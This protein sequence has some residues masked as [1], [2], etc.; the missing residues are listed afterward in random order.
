[1]VVRV[2]NRGQGEGS[3]RS[4]RG[5]V[6]EGRAFRKT[7]E[8]TPRGS[9]MWVLSVGTGSAVSLCLARVPGRSRHVPTVLW[10]SRQCWGERGGIISSSGRRDPSPWTHPR[11]Q[12]KITTVIMRREGG[13]RTIPSPATVSSGDWGASPSVRW[14]GADSY[15]SAACAP[16]D[17][18]KS[19]GRA[20]P[21]TPRNTGPRAARIKFCYTTRSLLVGRFRNPAVASWA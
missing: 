1:M 8:S 10:Q 21:N 9:R 14:N 2:R 15:G 7:H 3:G 4:S 13:K 11:I 12:N 19:P 5:L 20:L 16:G 17:S 18:S 6:V